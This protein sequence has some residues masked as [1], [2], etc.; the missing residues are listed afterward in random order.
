MTLIPTTPNRISKII[1][2]LKNKS[3]CGYDEIPLNILKISVPFIKSPLIYIINK[4]ITIGIFPEHLKYS[5]INPVFKSG[6]KA[7]MCNYRPIALLTSFSKIFEKIIYKRLYQHIISNNILAS[8]Q[9][10]F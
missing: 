1:K 2:S 5:Q 4:S 3:S 10:G 6:D 8:E 9:H 7:D